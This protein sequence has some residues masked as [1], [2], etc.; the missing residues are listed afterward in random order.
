VSA[1]GGCTAQDKKEAASPLTL[2][3]LPRSRPGDAPREGTGP[4]LRGRP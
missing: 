4:P 3:R 1:A 2:S